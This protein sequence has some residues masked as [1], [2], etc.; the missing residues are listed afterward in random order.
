MPPHAT[1]FELGERLFTGT[2]K[3][4]PSQGDSC[5]EFLRSIKKKGES[6]SPPAISP[7][8][9]FVRLYFPDRKGYAH[10][11][12]FAERYL[13]RSG[14]YRD[15]SDQE[16]FLLAKSADSVALEE[17]ISRA[18]R[19]EANFVIQKTQ[20]IHY[21]DPEFAPDVIISRCLQKVLGKGNSRFLTEFDSAGHF[22]RYFHSS[23]DNR[24]K[25]GYVKC[26]KLP[27]MLRDSADPDGEDKPSLIETIPDECSVDGHKSK[28]TAD[29][30]DVLRTAIDRCLNAEEREHLHLFAQGVSLQERM[31]RLGFSSPNATYINIMR[32]RDKVK[33][34]IKKHPEL[35]DL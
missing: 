1:N 30:A 26:S 4:P 21:K 27:V 3:Q 24:I 9:H 16:V 15:A 32:V 31:E 13:E 2:P 25:D 18:V 23:L 33:A 5:G 6:S 11:V 17:L 10:T 34:Y 20:S 8:P 35:F 19:R 12:D 22:F 14:R 28:S 29:L 7:T